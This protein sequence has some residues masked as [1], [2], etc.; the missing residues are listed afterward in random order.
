MGKDRHR[1]GISIRESNPSQTCARTLSHGERPPLG[2]EDNL[3]HF[4]P[5]KLVRESGFAPEPSPSR[6]EMLLVTPL[7]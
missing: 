3:W 6:G 1:V 7:P 2:V 5:S 4:G